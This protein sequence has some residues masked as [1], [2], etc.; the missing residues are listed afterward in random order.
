L[1][2]I[3]GIL[4]LLLAACAGA[5]D[6]AGNGP[7]TG[8]TAPLAPVVRDSAGVT[9][10]EHPA[11]AF[12][13]APRFVMSEKPVTEVKGSEFE[14][15]LTYVREPLVLR[16]G[17][18]ALYAEGSVAIIDQQGD[19]VKRI[20]RTGEGPGEF[21]AGEIAAGLGDTLLVQD[22]QNSRLSLV[23]PESGVVRSRPFQGYSRGNAFG[24][25]GQS[26]DG[27]ILLATNG[28][29]YTP[30]LTR[31][32]V[33]QWRSA[34]MPP[35]SDS[36]ILVDSVPGP[37]LVLRNGSPDI[38]MNTPLA[39][40]TA[41]GDE[42][43]VSRSGHW[44]L[45]RMRLDGSLVARI[46]VAAPRRATDAAGI[47]AEVDGRFAQMLEGIARG[48]VEGRAPDTSVVRKRLTEWPRADSLPLIAKAFIG[49]DGVAWIKDGGYMY[50]ES[51]WAW[52]AVQKDGTILGRLVGRGK[53]PVVAFGANRV[54]LKSED[55][56][57]F[58][59][60]RVHTL[61]VNR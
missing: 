36:I 61:A 10:Y 49:P 5:A 56:D 16:D 32:P 8:N 47:K 25:V 31:S 13:R 29:A 42:F 11:D 21:R 51:T 37:D 9:I 54:M 19:L 26:A 44:V 2:R 38:V 20:G 15:D 1:R 6:D 60:F 33:V 7:A 48:R 24:A 41:W 28:F 22:S 55:D 30:D 45:Q 50:A 23:V 34:R 3:G 46:V 40:T 27:G 58:V 17:R 53:D 18:I 4:P 39:V 59:T 35:G 52:T 57:G 14:M 43:L 12:D